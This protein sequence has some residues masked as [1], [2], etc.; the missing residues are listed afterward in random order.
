MSLMTT[1]G[2][3]V[4]Q[5]LVFFEGDVSGPW[6]DRL[7]LRR[8]RDSTWILLTSAMSRQVTDLSVVWIIGLVKSPSMLAG[9]IGSCYRFDPSVKDDR[10]DETGNCYLVA[11]RMAEFCVA[12][13]PAAVSEILGHS[14]WFQPDLGSGEREV[15]SEDPSPALA[16]DCQKAFY[17]A[18]QEH[19]VL[20]GIR[21]AI[22]A[23]SEVL[24]TAVRSTGVKL[25]S[26]HNKES[27]ITA[28]TSTR[29]EH[30]ILFKALGWLSNFGPGS[31]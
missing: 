8:D 11:A 12:L 27:G 13:P 31:L 5:V 26:Y 21:T 23:P 30:N 25:R 3:P 7:A 9:V 24:L 17:L 1:L 14:E 20:S 4:P 19:C 16:I 2:V 10:S 18:R 28:E 6:D 29:W 15:S 22:L